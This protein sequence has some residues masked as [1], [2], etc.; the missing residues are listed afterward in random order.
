M[1]LWFNCSHKKTSEPITR[2][3][4]GNEINR[5]VDTFV[6]CVS[7]GVQIPYSF[8]EGRKVGER[9][10]TAEESGELNVERA[11]HC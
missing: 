5:L 8:S 2:R 4:N 7:C 10:R 3:R 6:K 9:R 11:T 1:R